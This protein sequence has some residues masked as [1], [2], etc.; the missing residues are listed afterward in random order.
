MKENRAEREQN[1]FNQL[2]GKYESL[3]DLNQPAALYKVK[4]LCAQYVDFF[5][6]APTGS[7]LEI[8]C[9]TGFYTRHLAPYIDKREYI[10]TDISNEMLSIAQA[11]S[12]GVIKDNVSWKV[13]NCL[14]Y[15][16]NES[17]V[18][19]I[20]GH[21]ILHHLPLESAI[22]EMARILKPGGKIAFYEP[23]ILNPYVW[24]IKTIPKMRPQ[25]DTEDET[26][27]NPFKITKLLKKYGFCKIKVIPYEVMLNSTSSRFIPAAG[28][29]SYFI[30][31]LPFLRYLLGG[32]LKI[33]AEKS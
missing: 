20:T 26:A 19:I 23:N 29:L 2:A 10:A 3:Y 22:K 31:K 15:S 7:L 5:N 33:M 18:S 17:S 32:S 28:K 11:T 6:D 8:G 9:G 16:F 1:H 13:E 27:V 25:G 14:E 24:L 30:S 12:S 4:N 21:G